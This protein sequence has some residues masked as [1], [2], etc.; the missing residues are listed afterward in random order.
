MLAIVAITF[1][2][3]IIVMTVIGYVAGGDLNRFAIVLAD[4]L[5]LAIV[6][7]PPIYW[8][9]LVPIRSEY[10]KR[11]R[12]EGVAEDMGKLAV[13]DSLTRIMNRRGIT[14]SLLDAMAQAERYNTPLTIGMADIDH[15]KDVNDHYGHEAGD[16]VLVGV[17]EVMTDTLRMP[18]KVGRYGGEEFLI[19]LPHTTLAQGRKL[20]E[21]IRNTVRK[22]RFADPPEG[23]KVTISIGLVQFRQSEDLQQLLSKVDAA[24]YEAKEGGRDMVVVQKRPKA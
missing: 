7:A 13:T 6:I 10:A 24:L 4:A 19:V 14:V 8:L 12:A 20:A 5:L 2:A 16:Q 11:L 1:V 17:A 9:V 15:F 23:L 18:D 21:R 3:E 22:T